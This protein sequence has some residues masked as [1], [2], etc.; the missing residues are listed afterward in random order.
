MKNKRLSKLLIPDT[1]IHLGIMTL[2]VMIIAYYNLIIGSIGIFVMVYFVYYNWK[3][4]HDRKEMWT[5]YIENLSSDIDSVTRHAV[6][7]L[8]I[9]LSVIEFDG[10]IS[11]YNSKFSEMLD[12]KDLLEMNIEDLIPGLQLDGILQDKENMVVEVT[13]D[14]THYKVVHN[15]VKTHT[16][17]DERY[18]IMLYFIDITNFNNLKVK[19]NEEKPVIMFVQVDNYDDVLKNT[20]EANKPLVIAEIDRCIGLWSANMNALIQKYQKDKYIIFLENQNLEILETKKFTILD[21]IREIQVGNQ[22][23]I[24]LSIGV[25]VNGKN[26]AQLDAYA[27][28]AMDLAL[29]RGGDQAVVKKIRDLNF[30]GGKTKAVEKRN[31]V[32]ARVIAHALRQLID[33][34]KDVVIMGHKFPDMDSLG[35]ALGVYRAAKNRGKDAYIVLNSV[36]ESIRNLYDRIKEYEEYKFITSEEFLNRVSKDT[37]VVVVDTHRPGFTQCPQALDKADRIVLI[38]HHRRGAEFIENAV[39]TYLEPY[40]SSACELVSEILQY[41][42]DKINIE[43]I[44]AE[45]LLAG[46]T[47]DTKNFSFKTGVRTFEAASWLRRAGADTTN[48]RQLF[49][50]DLHTF[51]AIADVVKN[52]QEIGNNIALSVCSKGIENTSLVAAQ[53]ADEL[54]NIRG[55]TASFVLGIRDNDEIIISGRSLGDINVQVILEKLGGGGHLTVAGTQLKNHTIEEATSVLEKAIDEYFEEGEEL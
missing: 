24:T 33:Q 36:N 38:D 45:A 30:Y 51:V 32:R 28:A 11:W 43:K 5:K 6:L 19:Y 20:E 1:K 35:A 26:P 3:A 55:I 23:P 34:S 8:P 39:L 2:L 25:G 37:L 12:T 9:S 31:K 44:E 49:Q 48:V 41:M 50:D 17:M 13:I 42:Y 52:A 16:E 29:G 46:I 27:R 22:I 7:E 10:S 53:A 4:Q 14:N 21:E 18:I 54:L 15:I 47:V 40:A